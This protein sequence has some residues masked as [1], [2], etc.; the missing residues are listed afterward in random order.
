MTLNIGNS[1]FNKI[2]GEIQGIASQF[3]A[4]S[5]PGSTYINSVFGITG[6]I[7]QIV[8]GDDAQKASAIKGL[9]DKAMSLVEKIVNAQAE[10]KRKVDA[11]KKA[12]RSKCRS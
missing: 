4:G 11:D 6:D 10:A 7:E 9:M 12:K 2:F 1:E 3:G 8:S 5:L